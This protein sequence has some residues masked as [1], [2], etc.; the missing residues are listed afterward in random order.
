MEILIYLLKSASLL[1]LFFFGYEFLLRKET[2]FQANR[3]FLVAGIA[4][5]FLLPTLVFENVIWTGPVSNPFLNGIP[6]ANQATLPNGFWASLELAEFLLLGYALV[7]FFFFLR[8]M[9]QL[10]SLSILLK[11]NRVTYRKNG[12]C[13]RYV[14]DELG[15]FSFFNSVVINPQLY[16]AAQLDMILKH[17][18]VHV[19]QKHSLDLLLANLTCVM[20]WFNPLTWLYKKRI[21]QN[22]EYLADQETT[23]NLDSVK[24]YQRCLVSATVKAPIAFPVTNFH[25]SFIKK[26]ILMLHQNK[27]NRHSFLKTLLILPFLAFFVWG[28]QVQ[29][30][31]KEKPINNSISS[32][33]KS[34]GKIHRLTATMNDQEL[35]NLTQNLEKELNGTEVK[36]SKLERNSENQIIA[37]SIATQFENQNVFGEVISLNAETPIDTI[38][39]IPEGRNLSV[40]QDDLMT[41]INSKGSST[42]FDQKKYKVEIIAPGEE[43]RNPEPGTIYIYQDKQTQDAEPLYVVNGKIVSKEKAEAVNPSHIESIDVLKNLADVAVYGEKGKNGVVLIKTKKVASKG[44]YRVEY[45]DKNSLYFMNNKESTKEAVE[46]L[47][48]SEIKSV[49]VIKGKRAIQKYG[50]QAKNGVIEVS[51]KKKEE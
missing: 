9:M 32:E 4:T 28:F 43:P 5:A 48:P 37:I 36:F 49:N 14:S 22:L 31:E 50:D 24:T 51:T 33:K 8:L 38:L 12:I 45:V 16:S 1:S 6:I 34:D 21:S 26:R 27:S 41:K 44:K 11:K 18:E 46:A 39:L 35:E 10:G 17:E 42:T 30:I 47:A 20:L 2:L 25:Q 19:K 29:T 13:Y 3:L 15:P 23:A 40:S 7:T